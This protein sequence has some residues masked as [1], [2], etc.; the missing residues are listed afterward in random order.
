M[1]RRPQLSL[2]AAALLWACG[3]AGGGA[4]GATLTTTFVETA[5]ENC[6]NGGQR[7]LTGVDANGNGA[8]EP[9]EVR[10]TTFVCEAVGPSPWCATFA[11]GA[12]IQSVADWDRL[13]EAGCTRIDG[14]LEIRAPDVTAFERPSPL[15]RLGSL[16]V[17]NNRALRALRFPA[18]TTVDGDLWL[19][20]NPALASLSLPALETVGGDLA[21]TIMPALTALDLGALRATSQFTWLYDLGVTELDLS[22]LVAAGHLSVGANPALASLAL[23]ALASADAVEVYDNPGLAGLALPA[24]TALPS[25]SVLRNATLASVSLPA[26][27]ALTAADAES[28]IAENPALAAVDLGLLSAAGW[29]TLDLPEAVTSLDLT[30]LAAVGRLGVVAP[31]LTTFGLPLVTSVDELAVRGANLTTLDL[32]ALASVSGRLSLATTALTALELPALTGVGL[33]LGVT[34]AS[35]RDDPQTPEDEAGTPSALA[36]LRLPALRSVGFEL[37]ISDHPALAEVALPALADAGGLAVVRANALP[38][39][40]LPS[41]TRLVQ[42]VHIDSSILGDSVSTSSGRLVL[43]ADVGLGAF[44]APLLES[45][46]GGLTLVDADALTAF[47]LPA[48]ASVGPGGFTGGGVTVARNQALATLSLPALVTADG[49][50]LQQLPSLVAVDLPSLATCGD[51]LWVTDAAA[52]EALELPSLAQAA[53][54]KLSADPLLARVSLPALATVTHALDVSSNDAL[55]TL[56]LPALRKVGIRLHVYDNPRLPQCAALAVQAA[57]LPPFPTDVSVGYNDMAAA[58]P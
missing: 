46:A 53:D 10:D 31:G 40:A 17:Q 5:G 35:R 19:A 33:A 1:I 41:L 51:R 57:L 22:A 28:R 14:T 49:I 4:P 39:L 16:L 26:L 12:V 15:V 11:Q 13:A 18:L 27:E 2:T 48:L 7:V 6:P 8:L 20:E 52:L 24:L 29:L 45:A 32:G 38:S 30:R 9:A 3:P 55:A 42:R 54:L 37:T 21:V 44:D 34:T 50:Y 56:A 43:S 36:A 58:C 47:R 25:L 23:P